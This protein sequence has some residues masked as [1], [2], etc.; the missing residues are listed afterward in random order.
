MKTTLPKRHTGVGGYKDYVNKA[1]HP[2]NIY[3]NFERCPSKKHMYGWNTDVPAWDIMFTEDGANYTSVGV[4][5]VFADGV[6]GSL[7]D[8]TKTLENVSG[9]DPYELFVEL[10]NKADHFGVSEVAFDKTFRK[11]G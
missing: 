8:G 3:F 4:I 7:N 6:K 1:P 11:Y 2:T 9:T 5:T 10:V